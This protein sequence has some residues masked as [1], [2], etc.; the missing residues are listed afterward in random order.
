MREGS[1]GKM[2]GRE[3][4]REGKGVGERGKK[5]GQQF[6]GVIKNLRQTKTFSCVHTYVYATTSQIKI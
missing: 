5:E 4:G 2:K 3:G 1:K 6:M